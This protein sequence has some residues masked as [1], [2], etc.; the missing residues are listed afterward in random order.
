MKLFLE[1]LLKILPNIFILLFLYQFIYLLVGLFKKPMLFEAKKQHRYA[2]LISAKNEENVIAHLI[3]SILNQEYPKE[4]IQVFVVA[5]NCSDQT[6]DV[7]RGAGATVYERYDSQQLGKG[8]ALQ[9]LLRQIDKDYGLDTFE[10]YLVFDA[11]NLLEKNYIQEI[12]KVFDNGYRIITSYRNSKNYGSN[13]ISAGTGLWFLREA[14]FINNARMQLGVSCLVSGTGFLM[15]RDIVKSNDGWNFFLLT[16]DVQFSV[17]SILKG[18]KIGYCGD[19]VFY[20]EQPLR[21]TDSWNQRLR[22]TKGFYQVFYEYGSQLLKRFF[23]TASFTCYDVLITLTPG[24]VFL[25]SV[26]LIGVITAINSAMVMSVY[27][28]QILHTFLL[29]CATSYLL[30]FLLGMS[31]TL[32]E[33]K[34]IY[35]PNRKKILYMFTFPIFMF[36]YVPLSVIALFVKI[37]WKPILHAVSINAEQVKN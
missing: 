7:S 25:A 34:R 12:N 37:K 24:F 11:D 14:K 21:F 4:L 23:T 15:H 2:I 33:W 30:F 17:N 36:T 22:W 35:C 6:A 3:H 32:A 16:E 1:I 19:A 18:E 29:A 20:D 5:D 10:G 8:Y 26:L 13:W 28:A 31:T 27:F 9:Y